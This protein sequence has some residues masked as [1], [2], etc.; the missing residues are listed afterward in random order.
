MIKQLIST[1]LDTTPRQWLIFWAETFHFDYK[2]PKQQL[3]NI[4]YSFYGI[5]GT[6][7]LGSFALHLLLFA[8][9]VQSQKLSEDKLNSSTSEE[10]TLQDQ[11]TLAAL[12]AQQEM[13]EIT[14]VYYIDGKEK[15]KIIP[16]G[17]AILSDLLKKLKSGKNNWALSNKIVIP[18]AAASV[19]SNNAKNSN[20]SWQQAVETTE[21]KK[22]SPHA[23]ED[24]LTKQIA[25]YEPKFQGCYEKALLKDSS[26]NGKIEFLMQIGQNN[27]IANSHVRFEGVGLPAGKSQLEDCLQN[28]VSKI[29][30]TND[31]QDLNGKKIKFYAMLKAW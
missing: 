10:I 28:V 30:I 24:K 31:G 3:K 5:Q 19:L 20:F 27:N 26:M 15:T 6:A 25:Q 8:Y 17:N 22:D 13:I 1:F 7:L 2:N 21:Q 12:I 14:G 4:V 18:N 29:V 11:K 16:K 23:I 9:S